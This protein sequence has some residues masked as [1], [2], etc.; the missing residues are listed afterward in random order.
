MEKSYVKQQKL[1]PD[2]AAAVAKREAARARVQDRTMQA[3]GLT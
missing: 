1:S 2:E 3:F